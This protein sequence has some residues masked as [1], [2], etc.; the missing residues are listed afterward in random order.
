M[1]YNS[2]EYGM[3]GMVKSYLFGMIREPGPGP[4]PGGATEIAQLFREA[5]FTAV[6]LWWW[7]I[8]GMSCG[9]YMGNV[10]EISWYIYMWDICEI[11]DMGETFRGKKT[12]KTLGSSSWWGWW[13]PSLMAAA[14]GCC[15]ST[16]C[17]DF[18]ARSTVSNAAG[19]PGS[20][21]LWHFGCHRVHR[22]S[23]LGE[24]CLRFFPSILGKFFLRSW[25]VTPFPFDSFWHQGNF[26]LPIHL[27]GK[28]EG[29]C[30]QW[31]QHQ[32]ATELA[33]SA[34]GAIPILPIKTFGERKTIYS[35]KR[36]LFT[37][38]RY[39]RD[40]AHFSDL[41]LGGPFCFFDAPDWHGSTQ[42]IRD[43]HQ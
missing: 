16:L 32:L 36:I 3:A 7:E 5:G 22:I 15:R 21:S 19:G 23:F 4:V 17:H 2:D 20:S 25:C 34:G 35:W 41:F 8:F 29:A 13:I 10:W 6:F 9:K 27:Y 43:S 1:G 42:V 37:I 18:T 31:A 28:S 39:S 26:P 14:T 24:T 12:G 11:E 40:N 38:Q 33:P 30:V